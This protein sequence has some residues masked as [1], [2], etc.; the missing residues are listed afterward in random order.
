VASK[1]ILLIDDDDRSIAVVERAVLG[2]DIELEVIRDGSL[3]L[4]ALRDHNPHA[5]I[6]AVELSPQKQGYHLCRRLKKSPE[7]KSIPI[8]LTSVGDPYLDDHKKLSTRAD[9]Y[10]LK[11]FD[12]EAICGQLEALVGELPRRSQLGLH[13]GHSSGAYTE[14]PTVVADAILDIEE[15]DIVE[16]VEEAHEMGHGMN[17]SA[18]TPQSLNQRPA[19]SAF[20]AALDSLEF[21]AQLREHDARLHVMDPELPR[22]PALN[23]A[24]TPISTSV[25]ASAEQE[26]NLELVLREE[27]LNKQRV[28]LERL[29][30][31]HALG[32]ER[33]QREHSERLETLRTELEEELRRTKSELETALVELSQAR[34][35][36]EE[37]SAQVALEQE[38]MRTLRSELKAERDLG[39]RL[40]ERTRAELETRKEKLRE[41]SQILT[42]LLEEREDDRD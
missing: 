25:S 40:Q 18:A 1:R 39:L 12:G 11:P 6:L 5:V 22:N 20:D 28:E 13:V 35:A 26:F 8:V 41:A 3:A 32:I 21:D 29:A 33:L 9:A 17:R 14:D 27:E 34:T 4:K 23:L 16:T 2:R 30:G 37:S 42:A 10:V 19:P 15:T 38:E 24:S 31:E 7:F 36:L